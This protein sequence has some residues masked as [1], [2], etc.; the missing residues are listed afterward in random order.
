MARNLVGCVRNGIGS[1]RTIRRDLPIPV[2]YETITKD[3]S[4]QSRVEITFSLRVQYE[5]HV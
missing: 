1:L 4:V 2:L 3:V 5:Y